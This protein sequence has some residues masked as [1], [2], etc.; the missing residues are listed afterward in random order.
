MVENLHSL[1]ARRRRA[2][3]R[4]GHRGTKELDLILGRFAEARVAGMTNDQLCAFE[5]L[6]ELPDPEIESWVMHGA[7]SAP[8]GAVG[9][10]VRD[11]RRF[12]QLEQT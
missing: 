3:F 5:E 4:A 2:F 11:I 8:C 7:A 1:E 12:H 6:L 9:A 10:I